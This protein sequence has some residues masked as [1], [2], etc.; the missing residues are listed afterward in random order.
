MAQVIGGL[1]QRADII[2]EGTAIHL[3][4][5]ML[6]IADLDMIVEGTHGIGTDGARGRR[7]RHPLGIVMADTTARTP[8]IEVRGHL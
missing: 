7:H 8:G 3:Q 2:R 1:Q 6:H 4:A 5:A